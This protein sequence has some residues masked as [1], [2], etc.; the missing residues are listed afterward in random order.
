MFRTVFRLLWL[1]CVL[2]SAVHADAIEIDKPFVLKVGE[3]VTWGGG[4]ARLVFDRVV[5]DSRCPKGEQCIVAGTATMRFVLK[6]VGE[7]SREFDV[8]LPDRAWAPILAEGP[9]LL[10]TGLDPYPV[11]GRSASE[12][13]Y[14]ATLVL[15]SSS[16]TVER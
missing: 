2:V 1:C 16:P 4:R 10:V 11:S 3:H 15:R 14:Q 9:H 7:R 8:R 5:Q 12:E 6:V 13:Q